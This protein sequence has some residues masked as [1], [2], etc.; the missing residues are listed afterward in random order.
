MVWVKFLVSSIIIVMAAIKLAEYGDVISMRTKMGGMFIGLI[1]MASATSLPEFLTTINAINQNVPDLAAGNMFG[2]NM[3]NMLLLGIMDLLNTRV[4][5]LRKVAHRHTL[6]GSIAVFLMVLAIF[7]IM[8][9]IDVKIGWVGI[10]SLVIV[11]AYLAGLWIIRSNSPAPHETDH[12]DEILEEG[13]PNLKHAII[14]FAIATLVLVLIMPVL[15]DTSNQIAQI[16]GLGTGFIGTALVAFIT[17]LPELVTTITAVR[18]GVYD[19][20]IGN[21]FGSNMFNMFSL[22]ISDIFM[23]K[24]RFLGVISPDFILVGVI[25]LLLTLMAIIGNQA[26]LEKKFFFLEID[27]FLII[28]SYILGMLLIYNRGIGI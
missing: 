13:I 17:S 27:A 25:G 16:T 9:N 21:L 18:L 14:G 5:I 7:F 28:V 10:D 4:R 24:G 22:G 12:S 19:M 3:F 11:A 23:L 6:T 1:L 15:V 2:S 26:K 8:A 20:A